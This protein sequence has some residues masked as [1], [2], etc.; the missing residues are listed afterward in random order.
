MSPACLQ[1]GRVVVVG[2][3]GGGPYATA[4]AVLFPARTRALGLLAP[5]APTDWRRQQHRANLKSMGG[6]DK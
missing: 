6:F 1:V 3:S 4:F 2:C 5:L